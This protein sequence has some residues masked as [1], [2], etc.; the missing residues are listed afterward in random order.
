VASML[1][2]VGCE[3]VKSMG[4]LDFEISLD[5]MRSPSAKAS[6]FRRRLFTDIWSAGG[7]SWLMKP[8]KRMRERFLFHI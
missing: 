6:N 3:H 7:K 1:E 4:Q 5:N 8:L 2:K